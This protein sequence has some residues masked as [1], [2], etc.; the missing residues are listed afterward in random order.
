MTVFSQQVEDGPGL[1]R[2]KLH[3]VPGR[4]VRQFLHKQGIGIEPARHQTAQKR[5]LAT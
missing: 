1:D 4:F 2:K 5:A 3:A